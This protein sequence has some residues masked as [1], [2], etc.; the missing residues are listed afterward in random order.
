MREASLYALH[1]NEAE[2]NLFLLICVRSSKKYINKKWYW[3]KMKKRFITL[4]EPD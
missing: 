2:I 4:Y 1:C 3:K